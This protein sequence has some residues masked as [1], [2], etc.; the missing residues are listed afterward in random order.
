MSDA[1]G[2]SAARFGAD[3]AV[4]G[5]GQAP[6]LLGCDFSS[7]PTRRKPITVATGARQGQVVQLRELLSFSTLDAWQRWLQAQPG[8]VGAFDFPFGLPRELLQHWQWNGSWEEGMRRY[9]AMGRPE[10]RQRFKDFCA[11]RPV[12]AKFAHRATDSPAGS[13]SSMKWVNPPVAWMMH[14]GVTRLLD[15]GACFP[16]LGGVPASPRV[17]LE[18]YPGLLARDLLGRRSY[19][20]DTRARQTPQR[21]AARV[22]LLQRLAITGSERLGLR[23]A[24]SDAQRDVLVADAS[25]DQL[26]AVLCL[27]VAAWGA[28]QGPGAPGPGYGVPSHTDPLEGWIVGAGVAPVSVCE[29]AAAS[30]LP[31]RD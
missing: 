9:A 10:L 20:A 17:A 16:G 8:W 31:H 30:R 21:H 1:S 7:S 11:A 18:G 5:S 22:D 12:G 19:K 4:A 25:A 24:L 26:D 29:T 13:S 14:A 6:V 23:L 3:D 2:I 15:V 27:V 28:A